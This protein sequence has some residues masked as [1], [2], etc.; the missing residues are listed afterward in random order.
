MEESIELLYYDNSLHVPESLN[1]SIKLASTNLSK[2]QEYT[3]IPEKVIENPELF[4]SSQRSKC[5][6]SRVPRNSQL[7]IQTFIQKQLRKKE[8]S[9]RPVIKIIESKDLEHFAERNESQLM[10]PILPE[11]RGIL[12]NTIR[13][14]RE[15]FPCSRH[16]ESFDY[17]WESLRNQKKLTE[18]GNIIRPLSKK[19]FTRKAP[20]RF[21]PTNEIK[22]KKINIPNQLGITNLKNDLKLLIENNYEKLYKD[23][24][25]E[26]MIRN[27]DK[28]PFNLS[29]LRRNE[30]ESW[31]WSTPI[32]N[33][34]EK[35][36]VHFDSN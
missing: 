7:F 27:K 24:M 29:I 34:S 10:L 11:R 12:H 16:S 19:A 4:E 31:R 8:T 21:L 20:A 26:K 17:T 13:R 5:I 22:S 15:D 23:I 9:A 25:I 18:N 32:Y 36:E 6:S 30:N 28:N 2:S 14:G 3:F 1:N 33:Y 35:K